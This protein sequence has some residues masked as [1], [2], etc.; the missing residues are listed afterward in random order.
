MKKKLLA[1]AAAVCAVLLAVVI[2]ADFL[3]SRE[4][5]EV[6]LAM[7][8]TVNLDITGRKPEETAKEIKEEMMRLDTDLLSRTS[9][10]SELYAVN[11]GKTQVSDELAALLKELKQIEIDSGGAFCIALGVLSDLWGIGT[12]NSRVPSQAEIDTAIEN[13]KN[14]NIDG[15][16][17]Y[18]PEGVK[19]D[20]GAIGKG[21]ACDSIMDM[22]CDADHNKTV[23]AVGGSVLVYSSNKKETFTLGIRDPLGQATDYCAVLETAGTCVSTSGNY[24]RFF[25]DQNGNRYHH[26]F[27]PSTGYPADNG[28]ISVTVMTSSGCASDA[29]STACFVLGIEKSMPLLEKYGAD[30]VFITDNKEIFTTL[31]DGDIAS[32]TV[33]N[34]NYKLGELK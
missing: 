19:L 26:I 24:E 25:E 8:T 7:N 33:K 6:L 31:S 34:N 27:D 15:N 1:A 2:G 12:D 30:A 29:L 16:T 18:L 22:V 23:A 17:V 3:F 5:S 11:S 21:Y 20:M 28:L 10:S 13:A 9:T 4:I 32:L 14:W